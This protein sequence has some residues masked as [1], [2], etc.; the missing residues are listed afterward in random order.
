MIAN[1]LLLAASLL[2]GRVLYAGAFAYA[3]SL[4]MLSPYPQL[5]AAGPRT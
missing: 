3:D 5:D 4:N 2:A 1:V